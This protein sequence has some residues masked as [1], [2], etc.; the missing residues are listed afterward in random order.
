[1]RINDYILVLEQS[2]ALY[3]GNSGH[4]FCQG[5]LLLSVSVLKIS[6]NQEISFSVNSF[7]WENAKTNHLDNTKGSFLLEQPFPIKKI[8]V[9]KQLNIYI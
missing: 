3:I 8:I 2:I 5:L 1:M 6:I 4:L 9:T 7:C